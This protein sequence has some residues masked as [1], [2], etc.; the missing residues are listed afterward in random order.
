MHSYIVRQR[1]VYL[2]RS[3]LCHS[4]N[5]RNA[6]FFRLDLKKQS[7][8]TRF[9]ILL[10]DAV[11]VSY[12]LTLLAPPAGLEPATYWLTANRSTS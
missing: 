11:P 12:P 10:H 6:K 7:Q 1:F 5:L 8:R 3:V 4:V 9:Y 2:V